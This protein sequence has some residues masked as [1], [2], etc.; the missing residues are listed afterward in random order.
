M[1]I[2]VSPF[3]SLRT[4]ALCSAEARSWAC[5]DA[6]IVR[7]RMKVESLRT[8]AMR[9]PPCGFGPPRDGQSVR[10]SL[11]GEATCPVETDLFTECFDA[12]QAGSCVSRAGMIVARAELP[13]AAQ[14]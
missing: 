9:I 14:S 1:T 7:S 11:C 13:D 4:V 6:A 3:A 10:N 2:T 12:A 5:R 8:P